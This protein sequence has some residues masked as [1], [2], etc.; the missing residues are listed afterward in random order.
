MFIMDWTIIVIWIKSWTD[1]IEWSQATITNPEMLEY[2]ADQHKRR[3]MLHD[4]CQRVKRV[5]EPMSLKES[6]QPPAAAFMVGEDDDEY[7]NSSR[8]AAKLIS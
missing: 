1:Y 8:F 7:A 2:I 3:T 6:I 5:E 4:L